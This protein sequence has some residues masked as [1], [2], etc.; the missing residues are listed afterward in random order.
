MSTLIVFRIFV[1]C[2]IVGGLFLYPRRRGGLVMSINFK[3]TTV[4]ELVS[5]RMQVVSAA[6]IGQSTGFPEHVDISLE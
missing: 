6:V 1:P 4:Y 2:G 3:E 5:L